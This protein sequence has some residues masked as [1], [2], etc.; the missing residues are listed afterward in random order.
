MIVVGPAMI[1]NKKIL[2]ADEKGNKYYVYFTEETIL[3]ISEKFM[4]RGYTKDGQ[5]DIQ[6]MGPG[7]KDVYVAESWI[8]EDPEHDK[9]R[10]YGFTDLPKGTWMVKMR[11]VNKGIW[12]LVK[13]GK[14]RGFSVSGY[15][16]EYERTANELQFLKE[17]A[18]L[19]SK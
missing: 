13:E 12:K 7:E 15:F 16:E 2:R 14:L 4:K 8:I 3:Q 9:S 5:H 10:M 1:P 11:V 18:E 17:L 19:L 6:H